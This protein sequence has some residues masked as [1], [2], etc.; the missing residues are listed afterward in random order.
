MF[1]F[2]KY[3]CKSFSSSLE[4]FA[5]LP[6]FCIEAKSVV[7]DFLKNEITESQKNAAEKVLRVIQKAIDCK[8]YVCFEF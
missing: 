8:T 4:T 1:T 2:G 6:S 3:E 7:E 5:I